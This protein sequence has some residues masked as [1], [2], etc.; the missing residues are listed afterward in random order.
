MKKF[1]YKSIC[2]FLPAGVSN[3]MIEIQKLGRE[4]WELVAVCPTGSECGLSELTA[5]L[6][7]EM[8]TEV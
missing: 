2:C 8:L 6:K 5:F 4:G 3:M 1:D 7:R